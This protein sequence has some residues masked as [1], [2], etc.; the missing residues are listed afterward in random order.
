MNLLQATKVGDGTI[1]L[2]GATLSGLP[3]DAPLAAGEGLVFGI[4]PEHIELNTADSDGFDAHV[5]FAE[6]LGSTQYLYCTLDDGQGLIV[7]RREGDDIEGGSRVRLTA[8]STKRRFF[9]QSGERL[10]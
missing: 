1:K 9:R 5:D 8:P 2:A 7:E 6:Y 3:A 4:R 10:R